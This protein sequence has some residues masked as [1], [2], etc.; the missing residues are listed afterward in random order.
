MAPFGLKLCQNPFQTIPHI[1]FSDVE[2]VFSDFVFLERM[3]FNIL[4][5]FLRSND[6]TD[7]KIEFYAKRY[8]YRL[9]LRSVRL[10]IAENKSVH[11]YKGSKGLRV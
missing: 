3:F 7:V 10:K 1:S 5:R 2:N 4:V 8:A 11:V 9:I 6:Q